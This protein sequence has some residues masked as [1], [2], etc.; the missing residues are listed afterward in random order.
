MLEDILLNDLRRLYKKK[1]FKKL[2]VKKK[3][4][5]EKEI[6]ILKNYSLDDLTII[7]CS[8]YN[9]PDRE[10][11]P[12][13]YDSFESLGPYIKETFK[14]NYNSSE[15]KK[16]FKI[17]NF[18]YPQNKEDLSPHKEYTIDIPIDIFE[19]LQKFY[20]SKIKKIGS[21]TELE[22]IN[23]VRDELIEDDKLQ[24]E[25]YE[26][27]SKDMIN[28]LEL[29]RNIKILYQ[30]RKYFEQLILLGNKETKFPT[31]IDVNNKIIKYFYE[32]K[33]GLIFNTASE[34][35]IEYV[36]EISSKSYSPKK[37]I[38][39]TSELKTSP[40]E[41]L[42]E[43]KKII[44]ENKKNLEEK[45]YFLD[46]ISKIPENFYE[47][48]QVIDMLDTTKSNYYR[49]VKVFDL[50]DKI[51]KKLQENIEKRDLKRYK[52]IKENPE[53]TQKKL[54]K[55]FTISLMTLNEF[56]NNHPDLI[57]HK[58]NQKKERKKEKKIDY[59]DIISNIPK[60]VFEAKQVMENNDIPDYAFYKDLSKFDL[61]EKLNEKLQS[62]IKERDLK[63][64]EDIK[65]HMELTQ[66]EVAKKLGFPY[67]TL[68]RLFTDNPE[69]K[70][71]R[72]EYK[73]KKTI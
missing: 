46:I 50:K 13:F 69:L 9:T 35:K 40:E 4:V 36:T 20:Y 26:N 62:N 47:V 32:L 54:C 5:D 2:N 61:L 71:L 56:L 8:F 18:T 64:C 53:L 16:V 23:S 19:I 52:F 45:E 22:Y 44:I 28:Y 41:Q 37:I 21:E 3:I 31:F 11:F 66:K 29:N 43:T 6:L 58:R 27:F 39:R 73:S 14:K 1:K 30:Y 25:S 10:Q 15:I 57:I 12:L 68:R 65:K 33:K 70:K 67:G 72:Q 49:K 55:E 63:R 7:F 34:I 48:I 51:N 60:N 42:I 24:N 38:P 17:N 59:E